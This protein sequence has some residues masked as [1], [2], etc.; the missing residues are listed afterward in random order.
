MS[1]D[2]LDDFA[3]PGLP[4]GYRW[5][6]E[7]ESDVIW[8][9]NECYY[10]VRLEQKYRTEEKRGWIKTTPAREVWKTERQQMFKANESN[11]K[12]NALDAA[13]LLLLEKRKQIERKLVEDEVLGIYESR[14]IQALY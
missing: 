4:E 10:Y 7:K 1:H 3:L 14:K 6:I 2:E 5:K 9:S 8:S 12:K 13:Q 11:L